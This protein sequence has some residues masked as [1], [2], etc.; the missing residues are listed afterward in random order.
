MVSVKFTGGQSTWFWMEQFQKVF[1]CFDCFILSVGYFLL[2]CFYIFL[3]FVSRYPWKEEE[4]PW[5]KEGQRETQQREEYRVKLK[6]KQINK[7]LTCCKGHTHI[8]IDLAQLK[9]CENNT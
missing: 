6:I 5:R 2:I 1:V 8:G 7:A 9:K 4:H 3:A